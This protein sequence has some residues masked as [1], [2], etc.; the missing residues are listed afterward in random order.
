MK[1][2]KNEIKIGGEMTFFC[3]LDITKSG[4][5]RLEYAID[6]MKGNGKT[7]RKIFQIKE[8]FY[9]L[10]ELSFHKKHSFREMTTRKHYAGRHKL[11]IVINGI[12]M[13]IVPFSLE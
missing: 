1:I 3:K 2:D 4:K 7:S 5:F 10:G 13:E 6:F 8:G 11:S 9:K 12:E